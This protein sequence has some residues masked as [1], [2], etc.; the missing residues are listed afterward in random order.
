MEKVDY[1][2][3]FLTQVEID[4]LKSKKLN[5]RQMHIIDFMKSWSKS[6]S[7]DEGWF[8][9][10]NTQIGNEINASKPTI[11]K[12]LNIIKSLGLVENKLVK[13]E[14][15]NGAVNCYKLKINDTKNDTNFTQEK[16]GV[17]FTGHIIENE[18]VEGLKTT[19]K[20]LPSYS[21]YYYIK[22]KNNI[23]N[24]KKEIPMQY[25]VKTA[26]YE[27][28]FEYSSIEEFRIIYELTNEERREL[29]KSSHLS[30]ERDLEDK[31]R[32][33]P[34]ESHREENEGAE[35]QTTTSNE[36]VSGTS[37]SSPNK[38]FGEKL[39]EYWNRMDGVIKEINNLS[40][41][42]NSELQL[43]GDNKYPTMLKGAEEWLSKHKDRMSTKQKEICERKIELFKDALR[44]KIDVIHKHFG[45]DPKE[46]AF[47]D[48]KSLCDSVAN[49]S[50]EN[51]YNERYNKCKQW[52][53]KRVESKKLNEDEL[54][55]YSKELARAEVQFQQ[56]MQNNEIIQLSNKL[57]ETDKPTDTE[58]D[59]EEVGSFDFSEVEDYAFA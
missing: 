34:I 33:N 12:E 28:E 20:T 15:L 55:K 11:I 10:S 4:Y 39:K 18:E 21:Y 32:T 3:E 54:T 17:N 27:Y 23:Y 31:S 49:S 40:I 52:F 43:V 6:K 25:R 2:N 5:E 36:K 24:I 1:K 53:I 59:Y 22:E 56:N 41:S 58:D 45:K 57:Q 47:N 51:E 44:K 14:G 30:N 50:N 37:V 19:N 35:V 16:Q 48:F 42:T 8:T 26:D 29:K 13:V 46:V 9:L 7:D 38:V